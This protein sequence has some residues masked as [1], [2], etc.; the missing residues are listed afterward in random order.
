MNA[1]QVLIFDSG[2]G[3]LSVYHEI[4]QKNPY[5][6]SYYLFD[7]AYFPYGELKNDFLIKR[8]T[9]LLLSFVKK[10][11]I[12]LIVIACNTASTAA[13][14]ALRC[15]FTI[16]VVGVVP[17]IKPAARLTENGV[18]GLLATPA[19]VNRN[20]TSQLISLFAG[21]LEVL[22]IGSTELVKLAEEKLHGLVIN[23]D[24]LKK[25]LEP[26]LSLDKRPDTLVLGCT[27][28]PLLKKEIADCFK[29]VQLVDSGKA[30]AN[31]VH[32]LLDAQN[33]N[34]RQNQHH[35]YYTKRYTASK[36]QQLI[37]LKKRFSDYG[38]Y[39]LDY[40]TI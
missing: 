21:D 2:V 30:I 13:L 18:I 24:R 34:Q 32:Q 20:Y 37:I 28:F 38:F 29:G 19:T 1:K 12:D 4:I 7:N 22:K 40:Y 8:L 5:I 27:H 17:A 39:S 23:K 11:P 3:G 16:P 25:V 35:A 26:W 9:E 10:H 6:N 33:K 14:D 15:Q 36:N 31:R